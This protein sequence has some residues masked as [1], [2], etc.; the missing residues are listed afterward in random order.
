MILRVAAGYGNL[1]SAAFAA[2]IEILGVELDNGA[3][4]GSLLEKLA[5][6]IGSLGGKNGIILGVIDGDSAGISEKIAGE[7]REAKLTTGQ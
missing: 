1:G 3:I 5:D 6:S 2:N 4:K 7:N